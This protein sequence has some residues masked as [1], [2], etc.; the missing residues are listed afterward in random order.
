[1]VFNHSL[2][3]VEHYENVFSNFVLSTP[4]I[5]TPVIPPLFAVFTA[6]DV[7]HK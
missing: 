6:F 5:H 1:M 4:V 2:M 3:Q 7:Y